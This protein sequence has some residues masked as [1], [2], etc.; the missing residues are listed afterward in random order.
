MRTALAILASK[1]TAAIL[2]LLHKGSSKPGEV[3]L[4]IDPKIMTKI[5]YPKLKVV[6]TGTTG[7]TSIAGTIANVMEE[8][9]MSCA[10][11]IKGAN[12]TKGIISVL[13]KDCNLRGVMKSEALVLEVDER[14]VKE[15][16]KYMKPDYFIIN[17]LSRDQLSRNGH[18]GIVWKDIHNCI[19]DSMHLILNADDPLVTLMAHDHKGKTTFYG[20]SNTPYTTTKPNQN[21]LDLAYCPFCHTKLVFD[22]YHYGNLG[23]YH[24]PREDFTRPVPEF[25]V[26]ELNLEEKYMVINQNITLPLKNDILYTAYNNVASFA[27][28]KTIGIE[29]EALKKAFDALSLKVQRLEK[30]EINGRNTYVLTSKNETP[31]SY[32]QTIAYIQKDPDLKTV[33][34]GFE[35]VSGRYAYR[36]LSWLWDIYF[37]GLVDANIDKIVCVGPFASDL[38]NRLYY[39]GIPSKQIIVNYPIETII[40]TVKKE[41]KGKVYAM[42]YFDL[43]YKFR[44]LVRGD[45]K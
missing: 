31:I 40:Q 34:V 17:N 6:V 24:C 35:N 32:N 38:A 43:A 30:L 27:L 36:D 10:Q 39:A 13:V 42:V 25:Q 16:F 29:E 9:G 41:T 5:T 20:M 3:A 37:E 2:K 44:D 21:T 14:Y 7:K 19:E 26:T 11:N 8:C 28:C 33:V 12:L 23:G 4:A 45:K 1:I 22:Y 18:F 15:I